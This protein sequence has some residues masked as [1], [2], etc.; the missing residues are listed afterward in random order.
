M[1][2]LSLRRRDSEDFSNYQGQREDP[3]SRWPGAQVVAPGQGWAGRSRT[4]AAPGARGP[5]PW[6]LYL[7]DPWGA[8]GMK[9]LPDTDRG[10]LSCVS[11][12]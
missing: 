8:R 6:L 4:A 9:T 3:K 7:S 5:A 11:A 1:N 10:G 2:F 12:L